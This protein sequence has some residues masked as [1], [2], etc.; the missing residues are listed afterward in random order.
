MKLVSKQR[1]GSKVSDSLSAVARLASLVGEREA[2][3]EAN[4]SGVES[5]SIDQGNRA[6][7]ARAARGASEENPK[8]QSC[9]RR[10]R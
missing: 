7:S 6:A 5:C 8:A 1:I 9:L 2:A 3:A 10:V 4:I